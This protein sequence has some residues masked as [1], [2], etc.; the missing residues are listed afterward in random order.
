VVQLSLL[1][2]PEAQINYG[3][4]KDVSAETI[5]DAAVPLRIKWYGSSVFDIPVGK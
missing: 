3:S 1:K 4:G 5:A 2:S